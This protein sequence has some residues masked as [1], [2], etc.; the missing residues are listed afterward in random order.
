MMR[1]KANLT[2]RILD[3][4]LPCLMAAVAVFHIANILS[5]DIVIEARVD[6]ENVGYVSSYN[7]MTD[8]KRALESEISADI[9]EYTKLSNKIDYKI[10]YAKN[11]EFLTY[12]DCLAILENAASD[13]YSVGGMLWVDGV[14][15][16]ATEDTESLRALISDISDELLENADGYDRIEFDSEISI[17]EQY[18]PNEYFYPIDEINDMINPLA[19]NESVRVSAFASLAPSDEAVDPD[20]DFGLTRA[21]VNAQNVDK[22]LGYSLISTETVDEV[23]P[24]ETVYIDDP[25]SFVGKD[26][27]LQEGAD[28]FRTVT[29][30]ITHDES[31]TETSRKELSETIHEASVDEVIQRGTK[32]I[33]D[34]VPTGTFIAPCVAVKG[35][36]SG[37]GSRDLY[38]SYDFHLGIDMPGTKGDPI[39]ASDGGEVIWA[40]YTPSYGKSVRIK[41]NDGLE[42]LYAHMSKLL[43][44]VGDNVYQGQQIGE[45][46]QTGAA[47][48]VHLH[49]EIRIDSKTV[50]PLKY[51]TI[52]EVTE[53]EI[54]TLEA[55]QAWEARIYNK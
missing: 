24:F 40:G 23:V 19:A 16:A 48:G 7:E 1:K 45:M 50:N 28:G 42:T 54:K 29:Y 25:D 33:P 6:G 51:V 4:L 53:E 26:V 39:Y 13:E 10:A 12:D 18:C 55:G 8:A 3:I 32:P 5:Y 17:E 36:S 9:G 34:A 37:Y 15:T 31:G 35:I 41:H 20:V 14:M 52:P 44:E 47:Y 21:A 30:E 27:L 11:P 22:T 46:G 43:V 2:L 38:G 49:F